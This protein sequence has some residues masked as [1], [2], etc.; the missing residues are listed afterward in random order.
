MEERGM[1]GEGAERGAKGRKMG[2]KADLGRTSDISEAKVTCCQL[3]NLRSQG[4]Q[5][6]HVA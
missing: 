4:T 5:R 3:P 2:G 6:H 1:G